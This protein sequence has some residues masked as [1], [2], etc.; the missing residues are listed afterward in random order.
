MKHQERHPAFTRVELLCVVV[1][2]VVVA[3]WMGWAWQGWRKQNARA[4][5]VAQ[6]RE[7]GVAFLQCAQAQERLPRSAGKGRMATNDWIFWQANRVLGE[8]AIAPFYPD[9]AA[10]R[11][12]CPMDTKA[13]QRDYAYSYTMNEHLS[14]RRLLREGPRG[15]IMLAEEVQPNDGSWAPGNPADLLTGRHHGL[16]N[17]VFGDGH[18]QQVP[19]RPAMGP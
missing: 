12:R 18:V 2:L 15:I 8:S 11:L 9:F 6:M 16:A 13:A 14:Q 7:L 17:V 3:C 10:S 5:C 1:M 4:V 19:P